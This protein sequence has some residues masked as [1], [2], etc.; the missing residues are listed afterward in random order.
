MKAVLVA[1][2]GVMVDQVY[3]AVALVAD[4]VA[5]AVVMVYQVYR[6]DPVVMVAVMVDQVC[7]DDL[8]DP[9]Y[10]VGDQGGHDQHVPVS[11]Q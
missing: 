9:V 4:L 8:V 3:A 11:V 6:D 1:G 10:P 7:R 5:T 2:P